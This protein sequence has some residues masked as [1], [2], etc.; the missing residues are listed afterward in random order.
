MVGAARGGRPRRA[1][2]QRLSHQLPHLRRSLSRGLAPTCGGRLPASLP[3]RQRGNARLDRRPARR[4]RGRGLPEPRRDRPRCRQPPVRS[5]APLDR[6]SRIMG[7][8]GGRPGGAAR[9][10]ARRREERRPRD[11]GVRRD[12]PGEP[13][14]PLRAG[15]RRAPGPGAPARPPRSGLRRIPHGRRPRCALRLGRRLPV[16]ERD[17]DVWQRHAGSDG[18]RAGG[19]RLRLRRGARA[20]RERR[21]R[22]DG[23]NRRPAGLQR[24]GREARAR[25]RAGRTDAATGAGRDGRGRLGARRRAL[26]AAPDRG[27]PQ[28]GERS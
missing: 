18:E 20:H 22:P 16:P 1:R 9:R 10:T 5:G 23:P 7:S 17:R 28:G 8:V 24:G 11:R 26:R 4:A 21:E 25:A 2:L 15:G 6:P 14:A 12:A 27:R 19:D 3:Q 13:P